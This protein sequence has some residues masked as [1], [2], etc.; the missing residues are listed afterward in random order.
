[1]RARRALVVD[2]DD[3][4]REITKFALEALGGWDVLDTDRG[5]TAVG[6]A[7]EHQPDVVLL[8]VM[9]PDMDG[10]A[11]FRALQGDPR[12]SHLAVILLT[13]KLQVGENSDDVH[14]LAGVIH[15]PFDPLSLMDQIDRLLTRDR[16]LMPQSA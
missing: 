15:K 2:D 9:M 4:I 3:D 1:M 12:T 13:A 5:S 7:R 8:D 10:H 14:G 6:L 16:R 11:T